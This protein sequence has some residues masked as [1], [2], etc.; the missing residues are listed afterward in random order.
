VSSSD[1]S[2]TVSPANY[3]DDQAR[4]AVCSFDYIVQNHTTFQFET[5]LSS[6]GICLVTLPLTKIVRKSI[7][8]VQSHHGG[9]EYLLV[10]YSQP[11]LDVIIDTFEIRSE[12]MVRSSEFP[13][14]VRVKMSQLILR[15][16]P[17]D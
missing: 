14:V 1:L 11:I 5:T 4:G 3:C 8:I 2:L 10:L 9:A 16:K 6:N 15:Q 7:K 17:L 12:L 13:P